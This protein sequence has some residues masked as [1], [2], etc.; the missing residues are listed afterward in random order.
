MQDGNDGA[1]EEDD[2]QE[3]EDND[4]FIAAEDDLGVEG[5]DDETNREL[6][7]KNLS[8][9]EANGLKACVVAPRMGGLSHESF[10]DDMECVI[11]GFSTHDAM[12]VLTSHVGCII[13]PDVSNI[14]L[15]AFPP[16]DSTK[17]T[18]QTK[19]EP[20][21]QNK[22]MTLEAQT[23]MAKFVHNSTVKSKETLVT[24]LLKAHPTITNSRAQALRELDVI[25]EKMRNLGKGGGVVWEVKGEHLKKLGLKLKKKDLNKAPKESS[26]PKATEEKT[27]KE[28]KDPNAP[29]RNGNAYMFYSNAN[30][31]KVR[32]E[33]PNLQYN[34]ITKLLSEKFKALTAEERAPW[35]QNAAADKERYQKE[36]AEYS[37]TKTS[38]AAVSSAADKKDAASTTKASSSSPKPSAAVAADGQAKKPSSGKKRKKP[39]VSKASAKL[40]ASFMSLNKKPK[41]SS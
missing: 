40:L 15:D 4:G 31:S 5:D 14:C 28:K 39:V 41:T 20:S 19:K 22:E 16:S 9:K 23:I 6:R 24:E 3:D 18:S 35:D 7:K 30:R 21:T 8:C 2:M 10:E 17:D 36:M 34:E 11:E 13:T 25:A 33:N 12:D 26:P 29:K 37:S 27:K 1:D 38:A 32:A